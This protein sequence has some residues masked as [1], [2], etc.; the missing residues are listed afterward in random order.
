M[1]DEMH[2]NEGRNGVFMQQ[3][4]ERFGFWRWVVYKYCNEIVSERVGPGDDDDDEDDNARTTTMTTR[5]TH[6]TTQPP[7]WG[8]SQPAQPIRL[9]GGFW[10]SPNQAPKIAGTG[11][12]PEQTL[13]SRNTPPV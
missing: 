1:R 4:D 13:L 10:L 9:G 8:A 3:K 12:V 2:E 11:I 6:P 5:S 7:P